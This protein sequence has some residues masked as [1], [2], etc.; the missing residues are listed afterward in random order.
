ME[1]GQVN[2]MLPTADSSGGHPQPSRPAHDPEFDRVPARTPIRHAYYGDSSAYQRLVVNPFL[3]FLTLISWVAMTRLGYRN[4][5]LAVFL[6]A[7]GLPVLAYF[8]VQFHC[9]DCGATGRL[10]RWKDHACESV[11]ARRLAGRPRRF[12][13][14]NPRSQMLLWFYGLIVVA[15]YA[16]VLR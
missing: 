9:L 11:V 1:A 16:F 7:Q 5:L 2:S 13:G 6:L 15:W 14:P 4:R 8:A 10:S 12:R 3:A